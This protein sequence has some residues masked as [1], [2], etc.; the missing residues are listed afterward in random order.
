M[1]PGLLD[2]IDAHFFIE[3][4]LAC[5]HRGDPFPDEIRG[6]S[7]RGPMS[8]FRKTQEGG[9]YVGMLSRDTDTILIELMA[10]SECLAYLQRLPV[11]QP[12]KSLVL[13]LTT[14][15][16]VTSSHFKKVI[17]IAVLDWHVTHYSGVVPSQPPEPPDL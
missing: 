2:A 17:S 3:L 16:K 1:I 4:D 9:N 11:P 13:E 7:I 12:P 14:D 5:S 10:S 15:Y 6:A 8:A